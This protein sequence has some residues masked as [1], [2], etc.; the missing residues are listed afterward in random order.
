MN[1]QIE[2]V[3]KQFSWI[4]GLAGLVLLLGC[5][6]SDE[7]K[8]HR[9]ILMPTSEDGLTYLVDTSTIDVKITRLEKAFI[10]AKSGEQIAAF[11][12]D[13]PTF[14]DLYFVG[15]SEQIVPFQETMLRFTRHEQSDIWLAYFSQLSEGRIEAAA[16]TISSGFKK[17]KMLYPTAT[18]PDSL[19]TIITGFQAGAAFRMNER[20]IVLDLG[21]GGGSQSKYPPPSEAYPKYLLDQITYEHFPYLVARNIIQES[22]NLRNPNDQTLL[23][24]MIDS[25]KALY[26]L[27]TIYPNTADSLLI[28]YK[29]VD[30]ANADLN[31]STIWEHFVKNDLFY[32]T[33]EQIIKKYSGQRPN[34]QEIDNKCPGRISIWLG[35]QV[36]RSY[37]AHHPDVTIHELMVM[38]DAKEIFQES[39]FDPKKMQGKSKM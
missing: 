13:Y 6:D 3:M 22:F 2:I 36:I 31:L 23:A 21:Y 4:A 35:W 30:I 20:L 16:N 26:F 15:A 9:E 5:S 19:Y 29:G 27:E 38:T 8:W 37:M 7:A 17:I 10:Q 18:L 33:S 34:I 32:E 25:G 1:F 11:L 24:D 39:R 12:N 28:G 14:S